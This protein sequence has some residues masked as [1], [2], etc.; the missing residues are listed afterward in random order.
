[1]YLVASDKQL[2]VPIDGSDLS[3]HELTRGTRKAMIIGRS[4]TGKTT[5]LQFLFTSFAKEYST[6]QSLLLPILVDLRIHAIGQRSVEQIIGDQLAAG[7][8]ELPDD[9]IA[10]LIKKGSFLLLFDAL[11]EAR[12]QDVKNTLGTFLNRDAANVIVLA[13]QIDILKRP[14]LPVWTISEISADQAKAYLV[15][16]LGRDCWSELPQE[17]QQLAHNPQDLSVLSDIISSTGEAQVPT[18]RADIYSLLLRRDSAI[19]EW[20]DKDT[21]GIR[22]VYMV[23]FEMVRDGAASWTAGDLAVLARAAL[24][25]WTDVKE[26]SVVE[27][28]GAIVKTSMFMTLEQ[29]DGL[30]R[31]RETIAFRHELVGRFLA[32]RHIRTYLERDSTLIDEMLAEI[33]RWQDSLR[34]LIDEIS[35]SRVLNFVVDKLLS[36]GEPGMQLAAYALTTRV[37]RIEP[38]VLARYSTSRLAADAGLRVEE[39]S[40]S[41]KSAIVAGL[42]SKGLEVERIR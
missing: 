24:S 33:R 6:R 16:S 14:E 20:A 1:V 39:I 41:K 9:V 40:A 31:P 28:L 34:F 3:L 35:S 38:S 27:A 37:E 29:R 4:G 8:V 19:G 17:A 26:E 7:G 42:V 36:Y 10:F 2:S 30:G 5:L 23:A 18:K 22:A 21:P 12:E 11:N 25:R 15:K 32:A 13:G